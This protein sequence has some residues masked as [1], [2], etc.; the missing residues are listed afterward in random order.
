[1]R[2]L[3]MTGLW[4]LFFLASLTAC[5]PTLQPPTVL[6]R[7]QVERLQVPETKLRC[8]TRPEPPAEKSFI[9]PTG[10]ETKPLKQSHVAWYL[11]ELHAWGEGCEAKL[12]EVRELL[13]PSLAPMVPVE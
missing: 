11:A 7:I 4:P 13:R 2:R 9:G 5:A 10:I 3:L 6:T 8:Q 1:M 12:A